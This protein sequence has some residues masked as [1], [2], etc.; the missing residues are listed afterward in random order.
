MTSAVSSLLTRHEIQNKRFLFLYLLKLEASAITSDAETHNNQSKFIFYS[1]CT[2]QKNLFFWSDNTS[3]RTASLFALWI[4]FTKKGRKRTKRFHII[5][6]TNQIQAVLVHRLPWR[7]LELGTLI[8]VAH[9]FICGHSFPKGR[10]GWHSFSI[11]S[12]FNA[13]YFW[14]WCKSF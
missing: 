14:C 11:S 2:K 5:L 3:Y 12:F 13:T 10:G 6:A 9:K 7:I 4:L 8:K 1:P